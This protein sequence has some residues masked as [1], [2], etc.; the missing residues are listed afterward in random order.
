MTEYSNNIRNIL[1]VL[2][3]LIILYGAYKALF[4]TNE[5]LTIQQ[6][7]LKKIICK[8]GKTKSKKCVLLKCGIKN[9]KAKKTQFAVIKQGRSFK[10]I[11][12]C[13]GKK[14]FKLKSKSKKGY[15]CVK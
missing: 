15:K 5:G 6:K 12:F 4:V 11:K 1:F 10:C 7:E 8:K 2:T 9:L 3:V 13:K 14:R